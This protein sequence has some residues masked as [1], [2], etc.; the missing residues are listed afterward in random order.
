LR[1]VMQMRADQNVLADRQ[2]RKRLC[3]LEGPRYTAPREAVRHFAGDIVT[4]KADGAAARLEESGNDGK[5]RRLAGAIRT[6]QCGNTTFGR[7]E[8]SG[9]DGQ[10]TAE[11]TRDTINHKKW[12]SHGAPPEWRKQL[13]CRGASTICA[14]AKIH[15]STHVG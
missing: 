2:A 12:L 4:G 8:R 1:S 11:T 9:I 3:D 15:R 10:Q 14:L 5:K 13:A 7:S 6:Y